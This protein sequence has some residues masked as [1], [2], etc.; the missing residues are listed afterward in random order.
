[1]LPIEISL[2]KISAGDVLAPGWVVIGFCFFF[3]FFFSWITPFE[4][5][6]E[7]CNRWTTGECVS[8]PST[9][10]LGLHMQCNNRY[11]SLMC[12]EAACAMC[13]TTFF[14]SV[15]SWK[16]EASQAG[17]APKLV[18]AGIFFQ[19]MSTSTFLGKDIRTIKTHVIL[20]V[21]TLQ[22]S[23]DFEIGGFLSW[24]WFLYV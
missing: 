12:L 7:F 23:K 16:H 11:E 6:V 24:P 3:F 15:L 13:T 4:A 22:S 5:V 2:C 17:P 14:E 19:K 20:H 8:A 21:C 9:W 1:M 18:Y 10:S